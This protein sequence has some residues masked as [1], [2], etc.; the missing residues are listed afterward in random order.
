MNGFV[1]RLAGLPRNQAV[2]VV[3]EGAVGAEGFLVKE[4]LDAATEADL[5][6]MLLIADWPA[7]FAMPAAAKDQN[8]SASNS[9]GHQT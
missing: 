2:E 4:T 5:I 9:S 7:H 3:A 6:G 1:L 8:R